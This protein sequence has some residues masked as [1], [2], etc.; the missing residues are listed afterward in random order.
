MHLCIE[1]TCVSSF[2]PLSLI[3]SI[4]ILF[5]IVLLTPL[6]AWAYYMMMICNICNV[7]LYVHLCI[8]LVCVSCFYPL[9]LIVSRDMLFDIELSMS[10]L[11]PVFL[12]DDDI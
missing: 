9:S 5:A 4:N 2:D 11:C 7:S 10:L 3:A 6:F 1:L 12:Y 8:E